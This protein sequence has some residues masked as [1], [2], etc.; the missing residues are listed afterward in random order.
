[1]EIFKKTS[2][3]Q[4]W[5]RNEKKQ[6]KTICLVPTM[7]YLHKGH[8]S[9]IEQGK[10]ESDKT[11]L[12]IFV[13]PTQ[14]GENEDLDAYPADLKKD[15]SHAEE[16]NVDAV[17]LPSKDEM[18]KKN[19]QTYVELTNL[20]N[21]LCGFSRPVHFKGVAT[22]VAKLFN[23]VAPDTAVFGQKDFQQL[24]VIRQMTADMNFNI[25]II[26]APIIRE[27]DGLAM[28]SRNSYLSNEQRKSGLC[29]SKSIKKVKEMIRNG[30]TDAET[31]RKKI[32]KFIGGV[33]GAKIDYAVICDPETLAN[34]K[35]IEKETLFALAVKIGETRL[36]DNELITP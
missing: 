26:G 24:Q 9:L 25:K 4:S 17:F 12:S 23:I 5:S 21:H 29:L 18:Y 35:K 8:L 15:L 22:I 32:N 20:P 27:N 6:E 30:E 3:M 31:I 7:G 16:L 19:F 13:N 10:K 1:M 2:E 33:K 28:S 36:I 11:V 14:F 34:V